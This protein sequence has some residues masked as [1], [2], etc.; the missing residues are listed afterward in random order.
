MSEEE[1]YGV[2]WTYQIRYGSARGGYALA[3]TSDR[4]LGA[5]KSAFSHSLVIYLGPG[6]KATDKQRIEAQQVAQELKEIHELEMRKES[7]TRID[8]LKEGFWSGGH[9]RF[10]TADGT[11][12]IDTVSSN[13]GKAGVHNTAGQLMDALELLAPDRF[14]NEKTGVL[15]ETEAKNWMQT[16]KV[17]R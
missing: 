13:F 12:Q 2:I 8:W 5:A 1:L 7:V 16:H 4:I 14:Y 6:S 15:I 3:I 11:I 10:T 17:R 9:F